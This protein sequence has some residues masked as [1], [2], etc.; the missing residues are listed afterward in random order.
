MKENSLYDK[1]SL[2]SIWG[3]TKNFNELAKDCVAFSNAEGGTIDIGIEDQ[4]ALPPVGQKIPQELPTIVVNEISSKTCNVL[5][6]AKIQVAENGGEYLHLQIHRNS[7]ALSST[8]SG[9]FY[10]RIGDKSQPIGPEDISRLAADKGCFH[11]EDAKTP[12]NWH[13]ADPEKLENLLRNLKLSDRVSNFVKQKEIKEILDH[14]FL[15]DPDSDC[16]TNLG[17]LFI[18]RQT[19]RGRIPNAPIVQCIKYDQYGEKVNKW[20]WDDYTKNPCEM[21]NAIWNVIPEWKESTEISEGLLRRNILAYPEQVIRELLVNSFVHRSYTVK[22]DIFINIYPDHVEIVNPGRLPLGVTE[23]NILHMSRKRNEHFAKIFF[24]L[25][26]MEREGSGYDMMYETLLANGKS[27][28]VVKEGEDFVSVRVERRIV[29]KEVIKVMQYADQTYNMKQKQLICLGLITLHESLSASELIRLLGLRDANS[30]RPWLYPLI[31]KG[32]VTG[33][34]TRTKA[35]EYRVSP[36]LLQESQYKGKTSLKRIEDYRLKELIATDLELY[37]TASLK[38]LRLRIGEEIPAKKVRNQLQVL[39][40]EGRIR[41]VGANRWL[42]Y[43]FI[44]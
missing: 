35:K 29:N 18:G 16:M 12:F 44:K 25:H 42:K 23:E 43:E 40:D 38:D 10:L 30:L 15:T 11:W 32:L 14:Y 9:K 17:V 33:S 20:V 27:V 1:K 22:G 21:L 31:D 26:L 8:T 5:L 3:K 4:E 7:N 2:R 34:D 39:I 24:D 37:K 28:P 6:S 19:Q 36:L 13:D 41:K